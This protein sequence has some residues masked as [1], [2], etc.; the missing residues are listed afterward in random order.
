MTS[1]ARELTVAKLAVQR[2]SRLARAVA[3]SS[4]QAINKEDHSPVTVADFG[5]QAVIIG[6][7][8]RAFPHDKVV[9][10]EDAEK[11]REDPSLRAKVWQLVQDASTDGLSGEIGAL[12]TDED[13]CNAIDA[14]DYTGGSKGRMWALDPIDG[15]KGF[16]RGG[17]YAVCLA[18]IVDSRVV[19]GAVGCPNLGEGGGLFSA[20]EG[21]GAYQQP[22]FTDIASATTEK[23][24]F[25]NVGDVS[26]MSFCESVEAGHSDQTTNA[27]IAEILGIRNPPVRMDSQAKYCSVSRGDGD[28]YLRLPV[29]ATYEE[30]IW[31]HAAGNVIVQEAGGRVTDMYGKPLDFGQ[32]RTLKNNKGVIVA[33][34]AFQ[35][36]VLAAVTQALKE[37]GKL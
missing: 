35:D 8:K 4:T 29:K 7:I 17:Q 18:L 28:V 1:L 15:T 16:L 25:R 3:K 20:V 31:D 37:E 27:R 6:A 30:K 32:G 19:L 22:L 12:S 24:H 5:A 14:G 33:Q 13:M 2:A 10:E 9:G 36:K 34:A 23:I 26:E 11:L 21:Q